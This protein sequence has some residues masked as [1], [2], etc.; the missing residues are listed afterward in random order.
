MKTQYNLTTF[1][2][3]NDLNKLILVFVIG[4]LITTSLKIVILLSIFII[5]LSTSLIDLIILYNEFNSNLFL[6]IVDINYDKSMRSLSIVMINDE[7]IDDN[8]GL[9]EGIFNTLQNCDEFNNF[10]N[11]KIIILSCILENNKE[12]N[13]HSNVLINNLTTF[14]EYYNSISDDL[15]NYSNLQ[16]GYNNQLIIKFIIKAW[17]VSNFKNVRIKSTHNAITIERKSF[18]SQK[19]SYSTVASPKWSKGL[20]TPLSLYNQKGKL[21]LEN[22]K[23]IFTM[24]IETIKHNGFQTPIAISSC[25]P[26]GSNLFLIDHKLFLINSDQA[27]NQLWSQYFNYLINEIIQLNLDKV[28]IFAHNLG[29][30]DGYFSYKGL[31]NNYNP[32][33]VTSIIDH[34]NSFIS[35]T[36]K[37]KVI[38]EFKDSLR[39]FPMSLDKLCEL[40]VVTGKLIP[41]DIRF[42]DISLFNNH[43]LL[44]LFKKYALQDA[45]ALYESLKI[46]QSTYFDLFKIDIESVYSTATLALKIFRTK[47]LED[48]IF[49]LPQYMDTFIRQG[50]YGGGTDVYKAYGENIHY[51]DVNSLYPSAMLNPMPYNLVTPNLLDLTT[52]S[53]DTFFG[54]V[55]AEIYCPTDMLRPVLPYHSNGKTIYPTGV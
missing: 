3:S 26:T 14:E 17:D 15:D 39:I 43:N 42:N 30:F 55:K 35:I 44:I 16:Y 53:L 41:Y 31:L 24:D 48:N 7:L 1:K 8:E 34:G 38:L 21:I 10:G 54:F 32:E 46:A 20:I 49:I 25:G 29:D 33:N 47:F 13:L 40:F 9:F 51:Y 22:P 11:E 27:V 6:K 19:R 2:G 36:L 52:R 12:V 45:I 50:Y 23:T 18:N 28:T 5:Y 37:D 4:L